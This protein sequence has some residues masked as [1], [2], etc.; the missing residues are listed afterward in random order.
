VFIALLPFLL[1]TKFIQS[2]SATGRE[3]V[4]PAFVWRFL[5]L[6]SCQ[7]LVQPVLGK[8]GITGKITIGLPGHETVA[9]YLECLFTDE[10]LYKSLVSS[11]FATLVSRRVVAPVSGGN[12]PQTYVY[13]ISN[14]LRDA[15]ESF[16][17]DFNYGFYSIEFTLAVSEFFTTFSGSYF[18]PFDMVR[19]LPNR[20]ES[21]K[22]GIHK[23]RNSSNHY[24]YF[25]QKSAIDSVTDPVSQSLLLFV[26]YIYLP[27]FSFNGSFTLSNSGPLPNEVG[28]LLEALTPVDLFRSMFKITAETESKQNKG[29]GFANHNK[30]K[31]NNP[32]LNKAV[33]AKVLPDAVAEAKGNGQ[34][35]RSFSSNTSTVY[36]FRPSGFYAVANSIVYKTTSPITFYG[37][38]VEILRP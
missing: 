34:Q 35:D 4:L 27:K 12:D 33:D 15:L 6:F 29:N 28:L 25:A 3:C 11:N 1:T 24:L 37:G 31:K 10:F 30:G 36:V 26:L 21:T 9:E 17:E 14:D 38:R 8:A 5:E 19:R 13:T 22:V 16:Y 18:M 7:V 20:V 23:F 2:I 32:L